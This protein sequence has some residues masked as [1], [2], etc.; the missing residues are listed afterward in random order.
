MFFFVKSSI[1]VFNFIVLFKIKTGNFFSNS[2]WN[3][4][5]KLHS[6]IILSYIKL[7]VSQFS[8]ASTNN[9]LFV[10]VGYKTSPNISFLVNWN[11]IV[12]LPL[13]SYLIKLAVPRK[14]NTHLISF[15]YICCDNFSFFKW[16]FIYFNTIFTKIWKKFW[17][18]KI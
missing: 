5:L 1:L 11:I 13:K 7:R 18:V 14:Q 8:L 3:L 6:F 12:L 10:F 9:S 15:F 4:H 17:N 16:T 2:L